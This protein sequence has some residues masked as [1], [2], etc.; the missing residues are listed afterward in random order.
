MRNHFI[1]ELVKNAKHN[2][3]I[4]LIVGDLGYNVVEPFADTYPERFLNI[5]VAE[6]NMMGVAAGIASEGMH[7]FVYS[8]ANFPTFRCAEQIRNDVDYHK[9]SVTIVSVGGGFSYG[10]L[11]YSH[12]ALQDYGLMRLMPNTLICAPGD[13]I[14]TSMVI[15]YLLK[16]PQPSYLRIDKS[17]NDKI[18]EKVTKLSP[19]KWLCLKKRKSKKT[20]LT[21]GNTLNFYKKINKIEKYSNYNIYSL[22]IWGQS[23]KS[24]QIRKLKNFSHIITIE[25][26]YEDAGFGSWVREAA[27]SQL[28]LKIDSFSL[29]SKNIFN[30]GNQEFLNE[31]SGLLF[32]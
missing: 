22:P 16:N 29:N 5:G 3:K 30:V 11:G 4:F 15:N 32:E 19:G 12:H 6:Q 1:K 27:G 14:E 10:N 24:N 23:L 7:V 13:I 9:L 20:F 17:F 28:N 31:K 2:K 25:D 8:I 26:H 21:T 18:R